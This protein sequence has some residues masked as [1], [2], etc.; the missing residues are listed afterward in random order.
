VLPYILPAAVLLD[1]RHGAASPDTKTP[2][3]FVLQFYNV[4]DITCFI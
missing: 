3:I 1:D 4:D 2:A